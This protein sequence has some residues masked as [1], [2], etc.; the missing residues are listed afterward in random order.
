MKLEMAT[1][2]LADRYSVTFEQGIIVTE[3]EPGSEAEAKDIARGDIITSIQRQK[4]ASLSDFRRIKAELGD[5]TRPVLFL[6]TGGDGQP[7][8]VALK[9]R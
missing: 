9:N 6:V 3:V 1:P 8:F 5:R 7:R 2:A 4:V